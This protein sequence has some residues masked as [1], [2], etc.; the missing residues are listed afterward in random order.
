MTEKNITPE[1]R[2]IEFAELIKDLMLESDD[3]LCALAFALGIDYQ[4]M[5]F[6]LLTVSQET[7]LKTACVMQEDFE[8]G[9][10]KEDENGSLYS[11]DSVNNYGGFIDKELEE[12]IKKLDETK[13]KGRCSSCKHWTDFDVV[14]KELKICL[15]ASTHNDDAL[16]QATCYDEGI[17]G[18]LITHKDF[19]CILYES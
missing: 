14:D 12:Q 8:S 19:G 16:M 10:L 13:I 9:E 4:N 18:E 7:I 2:F 15:I 3:G 11:V 5:N 1:K 17:M 6:D